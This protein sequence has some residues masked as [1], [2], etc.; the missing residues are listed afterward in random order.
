METVKGFK[1]FVGEEAIKRQRIKNILI[2]CFSL[3]GFEPV[4]TPVIE[5]EKFVKGDNAQDEAVSDIFK[6]K[7]RG[8]R[9]LALRYEFTFQLKRLSKNKKLPY[10]RF[11]IGEVFRDEPI[12]SNRFRQFTQCDIDTIGSS[13]KDDAEILTLVSKILNELNIKY[14]INVNNRKLLN[15]ILDSE[16]I[17]NK[18]GVLREIDKLDKLSELEVKKNLKNIKAEKILKIFKEKESYFKKYKSYEEI[19]TL[20]KYCKYYGIKINFQPSLARGLSYYTGNV[21]EV[22]TKEFRETISAGGSYLVNG[23]QSTGISFGLERLSK[24]VKLDSKNKNILVVGLCED[25]KVINLVEKLRNKNIACN[26][27][28]GKLSKALQFANSKEISYVLIIGEKELSSG[29]FTLKN[30]KTGKENKISFDKL[31]KNFS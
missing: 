22:K 27:M 6:L 26:L 8:K 5:Y 20:K 30:M 12:S 10:K 19:K 7:D 14:V 9:N 21:F 23:I 1:D 31:I 16:G 2:K 13:I 25:S 18:E 3:Y 11:S 24:L 4:E 17:K 15:E 29:K 28:F